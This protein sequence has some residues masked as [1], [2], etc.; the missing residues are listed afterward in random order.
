MR[1]I[2]QEQEQVNSLRPTGVYSYVDNVQMWL[3]VPLGPRQRRWL[4]NRCDCYLDD[5]PARFNPRYRQRVQMRQP[6]ESVLGWIAEQP[7]AYVNR[8]E[9]ALDLVFASEEEKEQAEAFIRKHLVKNHRGKQEIQLQGGTTTMYL[10]ARNA[11]NNLVTYGNRE[12]RVT[13]EV[14]CLH[15]EWRKRGIAALR[16]EN[17]SAKNLNEIDHRDFWQRKLLLYVINPNKLGRE[18]RKVYPERR[19]RRKDQLL[20]Q[21]S[22]N[23]EKRTGQT[24]IKVIG[25][26]KGVESTQAVIDAFRGKLKVRKCSERVEVK[27]LLPSQENENLSE[28]VETVDEMR[29][30]IDGMRMEIDGRLQSTGN[31]DIRVF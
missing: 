5:Q 26:R 30:E 18:Y 31:E 8:L 2:E 1:N 19:H 12:C 24:L 16:Q 9:L 20:T 17:I 7:G 4:Q 22:Y 27:H 15:I 29:M 23:V 13:G 25:V 14:N 6:D 10:S 3:R 11:A 21:G 28:E